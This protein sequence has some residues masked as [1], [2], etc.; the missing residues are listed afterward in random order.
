[1]FKSGSVAIIGSPNAG[2]STLLNNLLN[3]KIAITSDK[4]NTTRNMI[5]GIHNDEDSQII[6]IDTP[7]INKPQNKL[8]VYMKNQIEEAINSVDMIIYIVDAKVGIKAKEIEIIEKIKKYKNIPK[9][10]FINKIDLI[11]QNKVVEIIEKLKNEE[12]FFD[13]FALSLK[14]KFNSQ[15]LIDIIKKTLPEGDIYYD[16]EQFTDFTTNF[17]LSELIRE[18]VFRNTHDEIPH[19]VRVKIDEV[20]KTENQIYVNAI[21]YVE[22]ES[23]KGI[24]IGK[25][26][27]MIRTIGQNS[28]YEIERYFNQ[29]VFIDL[30]VRVDK[31]WTNKDY[32][33]DTI[34]Y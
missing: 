34:N 1:M 33:F 22:R 8:Q 17:Y 11:E 16:R 5:R 26:G 32:D 10:A 24:I 7:G 25:K 13:I 15:N 23:Q 9:L 27:Q 19:G 31:K 2:K 12:V 6:F 30:V 3:S 18:K 20:D 14:E 4:V 21:I 29:K 28:R